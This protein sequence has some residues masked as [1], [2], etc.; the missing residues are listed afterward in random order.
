MLNDIE[1]DAATRDAIAIRVR[2]NVAP[3]GIAAAL[4]LYFFYSG[5]SFVFP[6]GNDLFAI[7]G[8]IFIYTLQIGGFAMVVSA[9]FSLTGMLAA[10]LF[11]G[12]FT[13]LIGFG[14][15][16]GSG[17]MM[18]GGGSGFLTFIFGLLFAGSGGRSLQA[19]RQLGSL[20]H[21]LPEVL[22]PRSGRVEDGPPPHAGQAAAH[23]EA[24]VA[25]EVGDE[26]PHPVGHQPTNPDEPPSGF[27]ASFAPK[28][29]DDV[30]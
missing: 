14:F 30:E 2:Q 13:L 12:V 16:A 27:L 1:T 20:D 4:M 22:R 15:C 19:W 21:T 29:S 18:L 7:G 28:D 3:A 25:Q 24:D 5:G 9:I 17:L 10:L 11:D 8:A 23:F 26:S 6:E